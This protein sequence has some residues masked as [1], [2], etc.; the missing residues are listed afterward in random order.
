MQKIRRIPEFEYPEIKDKKILK[1]TEP[2]INFYAR[3]ARMKAR[4][5]P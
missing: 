2:A 5:I 3:V 1:D 4:P